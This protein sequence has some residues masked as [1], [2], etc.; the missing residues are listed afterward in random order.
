MINLGSSA[1]AQEEGSSS[2][3]VYIALDPQIVTNFA[4]ENSKKLGYLRITIEIML[5]Q[6]KFI[7]HIERHMPL[8]R[9]TAIEVIGSQ[10][11]QQVRSLTG[12]EQMRRQILRQFKNKLVRETENEVIKDII[13]TQYL[14]QGG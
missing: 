9:A 1:L 10:T 11:E 8:L 14:I 12:R 6:P 2:N 13:F 3:Y 7:E 4:G 5:D